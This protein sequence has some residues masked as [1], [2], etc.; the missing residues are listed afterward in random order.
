MVYRNISRCGRVGPSRSR[1]ETAAPTWA[2]RW[3]GTRSPRCPPACVHNPESK[4]RSRRA[5]HWT[6]ELIAHTSALTLSLSLSFY[7]HSS[8]LHRRSEWA[9]RSQPHTALPALCSTT[10]SQAGAV[11][12]TADALSTGLQRADGRYRTDCTRRAPREAIHCSWR[13]EET[14]RGIP[15]SAGRERSGEEGR[16]VRE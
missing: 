12:G 6:A 5:Q 4:A 7:S 3:R 1:R 15:S 8:T 10:R 9:R 11:D 13:D 14:R 16:P 2:S